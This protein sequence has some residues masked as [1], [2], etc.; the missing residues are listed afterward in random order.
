MV[1][2]GY[3]ILALMNQSPPRLFSRL[4]S[5]LV[6]GTAFSLLVPVGRA[7]DDFE[8]TY[9]ETVETYAILPNGED[10]DS[11]SEYERSRLRY[12]PAD[13]LTKTKGWASDRG[14]YRETVFENP[15]NGKEEWRKRVVARLVSDDG[16]RWAYSPSGELLRHVPSANINYTDDQR[17]LVEAAMDGRLLPYRTRVF[18]TPDELET[19]VARGYE[20]TRASDLVRRNRSSSDPGRGAVEK[21]AFDW[22][23][24]LPETLILTR[25]DEVITFDRDSRIETT[26][27]FDDEG[28][29]VGFLATRY[30]G[31][32]LRNGD[33]AFVVVS[34]LRS[35][36]DTLS[37][38]VI[39]MRSEVRT[40]DRYRFK[41][42]GIDQFAA[43]LA[44]DDVSVFPNPL[45][46]RRF[47]I[48][49]PGTAAASDDARVSLYSPT[50]ER[51]LQRRATS[52]P[53]G[54]MTVDLPD[55]LPAGVYFLGIESGSHHWNRTILIQ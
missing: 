36:Y 42:A 5:G 2:A 9:R 7:Q 52:M 27:S 41:R 48:V 32:L 46:G 22:D 26:T 15:F 14:L 29:P 51:V 50:G 19:W 12:T 49:I 45:S 3:R 40:R 34:E 44:I 30:G 13:T 23:F 18:P 8:L 11:L 20:L 35:H 16:G 43:P 38:G 53:G 28:I 31:T 54:F 33:T 6:F 10:L 47:S 55:S 1:N 17:E 37:S 39:V 21:A 24:D 25:A 4:R